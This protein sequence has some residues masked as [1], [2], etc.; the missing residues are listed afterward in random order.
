[1]AC[2]ARH[3]DLSK[4]SSVVVPDADDETDLIDL[5]VRDFSLQH[6][7][8]YNSGFDEISHIYRL[9][10]SS[11]LPIKVAQSVYEYQLRAVAAEDNCSTLLYGDGADGIFAGSYTKASPFTWRNIC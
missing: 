6:S 11:G 9:I 3:N 5:T 10:C 7:Y 8:I 2:F 4:F 1:M